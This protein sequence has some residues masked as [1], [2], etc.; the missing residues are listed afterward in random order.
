M[1]RAALRGILAAKAAWW[2][3]V[4]VSSLVSVLVGV[5]LVQS[6]GTDASNPEIQA[7]LRREGLGADHVSSV[8]LSISV[9][10]IPVAVIVLASVSSAAVAT[11]AR[12]LARWR[13]AGASPALLA[14]FV[15]FQLAIVALLGGAAGAT[16]TAILGG[17]LSEL[18]NRW[19]LPALAE[20]A[21]DPTPQALLVALLAPP[22][23][24]VIAGL[25]PALRGARVPAIRAVRSDAEASGRIGIRRWVGAGAGL[26]ALVAIS[27]PVYRR[28]PGIDHGE[29]LT[30]GL[31]LAVLVLVVAGVGARVLVPALVSAISHVLPVPG[32]VWA[33]ARNSA[34]AR[35]HVSGSTVVA[36][37]CGSGVLGA[38][39]GMARTSEAIVR[40]LGS[41]DEYNLLDTYVICGVIGLLCVVGG[42]CV[43]ALSAGDRR[44]EVAVLR[45]AG[46]TPAQI[47]YVAGVEGVLLTGA[48]TLIGI[49]AT[50]LSTGVVSRA[51][52]VDGLPVRFILPWTELAV[53]TAVTMVVLVAA[54]V[55]PSFRALHA[56][57]R[58]SL[59]AE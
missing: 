17:R 31:G 35:A 6:L 50:V 21:V 18:L 8:G 25:L 10:I 39:T 40:A 16:A 47:L 43:L 15:M 45:T 41:H 29:A 48:S 12:D 44:R 42:A 52:A 3:P 22:A 59:A 32:A 51:A 1:I 38:I 11:M 28:P 20:V 4:L 23:I 13:L 7:V 14:S 55:V 56:P 33:L 19:I 9:M 24:V 53:A 54:L 27:V 58:T 46:M 26:C 57:V 30:A 36:L 2:A 49:T 37:A 34:V 5:C